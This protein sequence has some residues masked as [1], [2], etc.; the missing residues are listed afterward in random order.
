MLT[1]EVARFDIGYN[2]ILERPFLLRFMAVIHTAY[3]TK[4]PDPKEVITLKSDQRDALAYENVALTHAGRLREKEA[5]NLPANV[6]KTHGGGTSAR[7]VTP[8]SVAGDTFKMH[9]AKKGMT[10]T[11]A[12]T[13]RANDQLVADER[14]G[15]IDN[16]IQ[17]DPSNDEKSFVSVQS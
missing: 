13:Q 11:P 16:E 7:I 6:A 9:V 14:K 10:V 12:S 8:G 15:P 17:V 1:F 4:M 5:Q 3:A 2:C